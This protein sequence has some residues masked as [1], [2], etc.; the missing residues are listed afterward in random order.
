MGKPA[1]SLKRQVGFENGMKMTKMTKMH[2]DLNQTLTI[3]VWNIG[4]QRGKHP[5]LLK[6]AL[7]NHESIQKL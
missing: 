3:E 7:K 1:V 4:I 6:S 2:T 5:E